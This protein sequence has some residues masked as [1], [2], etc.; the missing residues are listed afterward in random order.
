MRMVPG[1]DGFKTFQHKA[2]DRHADAL[3]RLAQRASKKGA[4]PNLCTLVLRSPSSAPAHA[5]ITMK[6]SL[7]SAG[8]QAR[9]ILAKLDPEQDLC[10]L[11]G[12]LRSLAPETA[13]GVLIR[14]VRNSRL[15]D[16]HEQAT[17]GLDMCWSGDPMSRDRNKRNSLA[18]F[19]ATPDAAFHAA[20]GFKALWGASVPVPPNRLNVE[21]LAKR[22]GAPEQANDG[23]MTALRPPAEGWPLV[24][25]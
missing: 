17:Y 5:L 1:P 23:S 15:W 7:A 3:S 10:A 12:T 22:A 14:W 8:V 4:P 20:Q 25:H 9:A 24:R 2:L 11:L 13:D 21:A 6:D 16:V 19:E 18:L